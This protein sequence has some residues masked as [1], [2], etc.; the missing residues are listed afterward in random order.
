MKAAAFRDNPLHVAI[1]PVANENVMEV[2]FQERERLE[3]LDPSQ[4][5]VAV[6]DTSLERPTIVAYARWSLPLRLIN[7]MQQTASG[8]LL[9]KDVSLTRFSNNASKCPPLPDGSN[10]T[11]NAVFLSK[12][13][14][15]RSQ[16]FHKET[17]YGGYTLFLISQ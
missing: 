17:D 4:A 12:I 1:Y 3:L 7:E 10:A 6:V 11:F 9:A 8:P 16:Y 13:A 5:L 14:I 15:K 2:F